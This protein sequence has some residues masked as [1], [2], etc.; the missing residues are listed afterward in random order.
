MQ[1]QVRL[2][3]LHT[4]KR[5]L[6]TRPVSPL[7]LHNFNRR[8]GRGE[9]RGVGGTKSLFKAKK[10]KRNRSRVPGKNMTRHLHILSQ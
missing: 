10:Q 3:P 2:L 9:D 1:L 8:G 6:L 4:T 5:L 7:N